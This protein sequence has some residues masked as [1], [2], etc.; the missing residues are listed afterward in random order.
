M[1]SKDNRK[2]ILVELN[3]INFSIVEKYIQLFPGRFQSL[4]RL[5]KL[6]AIITKSE[7]KYEELEPWIQWVTVHSGKTYEQHKIFHLGDIVGSKVP[8]IFEQVEKMGVK[9]GCISPMNAENRLLKPAY[10]IPDPWTQ[11][12]SD[13]SW[14]SLE[15]SRAISQAVNDNSKSHISVRSAFVFLLAFLRFSN[16]YHYF[17]YL[18]LAV[19]SRGAPWRKALLLDLFLHDF[20][21]KLM[22]RTQPGFSTVFLNAGAH[23]QHHYFLNAEP[24]KRQTSLRNPFW[25]VEDCK[26]PMV[27]LLEVYDIIIGEL[28]ALKQADLVIAT[29]LSQKPYD[30]I[31]FYYR[32]RNHSEFLAEIG[33]D[34]CAV[35]PRMTRDFLIKFDSFEATALAQDRLSSLRVSTTGLALFEGI[36]NQG[37]SLFVT[38][39]YPQEIYADT[40]LEGDGLLIPLLPE[41]TFVAIKNGMHQSEGYAFFTDGLKVYAPVD[42]SHVK[43]LYD[44]IMQYVHCELL[45]QSQL[46]PK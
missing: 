7:N 30:R 36:E 41:V 31:K 20:H 18:S 3:E 33:I 45:E 28:L 8:Q 22:R 40:M 11:T 35:Y 39:T 2:L 44:S 46:K 4:E 27:D 10:F 5:Q 12:R 13:D 42:G 23:I 38:L 6:H 25:Y 16:L 15:L 37:K 14:W 9:V 1:V 24:I 29:G 26:D 19:R 32:L 43:N 34:F 17:R 21:L